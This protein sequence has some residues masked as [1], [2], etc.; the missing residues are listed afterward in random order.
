M[1]I[2]ILKSKKYNIYIYIRFGCNFKICEHQIS[3]FLL[4]A[5]PSQVIINLNSFENDL[6]NFNIV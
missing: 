5:A 3:F 2:Y 6:F 4:Q 1:H